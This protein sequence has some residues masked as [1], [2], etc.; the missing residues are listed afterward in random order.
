MPTI[1]RERLKW[2]ARYRFAHPRDLTAHCETAIE[3]RRSAS[4]RMQAQWGLWF[5][6]LR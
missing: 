4:R 6:R 1:Y 5:G 2:W 3:K